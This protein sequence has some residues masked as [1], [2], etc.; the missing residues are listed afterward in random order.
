MLLAKID[1]GFDGLGGLDLVAQAEI[2]RRD[3]RSAIATEPLEQSIDGRARNFERRGDL[4]GIEASLP[5]S[6]HRLADRHWDGARHGRTSRYRDQ[7][8]HPPLC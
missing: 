5:K 2:L 7:D 8:E 6:E 3:A 4:R 1:G